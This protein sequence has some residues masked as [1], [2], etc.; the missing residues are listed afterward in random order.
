MND[1]NTEDNIK[2][3]AAQQQDDAGED[4]PQESSDVPQGGEDAESAVSS[5]S[6]TASG[7]DLPAQKD[8]LAEL[9]QKYDE[10]H[11]QLLRKAADFDNY[12]KRSMKQLGECREQSYAT[13]LT[14]LL[15]TIDNL[16]RVI[17][18]S[19]G[20]DEA[21]KQL[22]NGIEMT[23]TN[24]LSMLH[25]K[26]NLESYGKAD[27]EFDPNLHEAIQSVPSDVKVPTIL[28]VVLPGY[29]ICAGSL[30]GKVLRHASVVVST[31]QETK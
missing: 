17:A 8:P 31:P 9:Q 26:Y 14:D 18:A 12:R 28:Q 5:D 3:Q 1:V 24:L 21:T 23:R 25:D 30:L 6:D 10:E 27:D 22:L 4:T 13:L 15:G 20:Q 7:E 16:D 11:D 29:R 2:D 19:S